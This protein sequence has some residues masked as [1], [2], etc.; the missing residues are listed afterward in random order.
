MIDHNSILNKLSN[1]QSPSYPCHPNDR[2]IGWPGLY[3]IRLAIKR[4]H[5]KKLFDENHTREEIINILIKNS[6]DQLPL[7]VEAERQIRETIRKIFTH[8]EYKAMHE[9]IIKF[10][11]HTF[12]TVPVKD[13][14]HIIFPKEPYEFEKKFNPIEADE[15]NV[16]KEEV[17]MLKQS[18]IP[19]STTINL[20]RVLLYWINMSSNE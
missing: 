2:F 12:E 18:I 6:H 14:D 5:R 7:I 13:F 17:M 3:W 11:N 16:L 20:N 10:T 8:G 9:K 4:Q 19:F 15:V 1:L